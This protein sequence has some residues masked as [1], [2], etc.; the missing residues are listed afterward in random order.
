M[1]RYSHRERLEL[2][3]RGEKPD[4]FAASFWRHFFHKEHYAEGTA[5]AMLDFQK[6]FDWD[7]MKINPR[8]DYHVEGWGLKQEWSHDEFT[9]H[10]KSN[11]PVSKLEDWRDIEPLKLSSPVLDEHLRVVSIIRKNV[12]AGFPILMTVFTPLA[13]AGRLVDDDNLLAEHIHEHPDKVLPAMEAITQTFEQF[14]VELRNAGADGIFFATTQWASS[15]LISWEEYERF[16]VP[17]DRRVIEAAGEDAINLFHVCSSSNYLKELV[18]LDY[19]CKM[20]NW[21]SDDPTNAPVDRGLEMISDKA[22][23]G[24]VDRNGWL[25]HASPDEIKYKL[26]DMTNRFDPSRLIIGPGCSIPPEVPM[27]N[28]AAIREKL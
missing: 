8:A 7:F 12:P 4:R 18:K 22:I 5:E 27:E 25:L 13:V 9:K 23:V 3:F 26:G 17:Y 19:P 10:R 6:R 11:F 15:N 2:I 16:G 28:L 20:Y 14:V 24:G 21:D 1:D